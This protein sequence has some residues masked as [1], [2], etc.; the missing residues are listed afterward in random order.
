MAKIRKKASNG[1]GSIFKDKNGKWRSCITIGKDP[2][3]GKQKKQWFYGSSEKEVKDKKLK[4]L[5]QIQNGDYLEPSK[6]TLE[7]WLHTWLWEYKR[8]KLER[9]TFESYDSLVNNHVNPIIGKVLLNK[10]R[11]EH[12]QKLYNTKFHEGRMDGTGGL[13]ARSVKYIHTVLHQALGQAIKNG[14]LIKNIADATIP[15]KEIKKEMR[16]LS[17]GEQEKYTSAIGS[18]RLRALFLLAPACG[19]RQGELLALKWDDIDFDKNTVR[20]DETLKRLKTYKSSG[21]KTEVVFKIPKTSTSNRIIPVPS[22]IMYE[23]KE[24]R[25]RQLEEKFRIGSDYVDNNLVFCT[26]FGNPM[27]VSNMMRAYRRVLKRSGIDLSGVTFH[28]L[29]HVYGTRLNELGVDPKTIQKLM[30]HKDIKTT[31]NTYVHSST[32]K[33]VEAAGKLEVLLS[34]M[35]RES[36]QIY[37]AH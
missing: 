26:E 24:H 29:R 17:I 11:P 36:V 19:A 34:N 15:P 12:L 23:L 3:T 30:G 32:E 13:S 37:V 16:V 33:Q 35:I 14:L 25:K 6:I 28:T 1:E 22:L 4:A 9:S 31:M 10:L 18:E 20:V 2:I 5:S 7:Q 27:D 8:L 21:N